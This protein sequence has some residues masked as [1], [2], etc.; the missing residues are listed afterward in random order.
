M[1]LAQIKAYVASMTDDIDMAYFTTTELT[2]YANQMLR[3]TQKLLLQA[4]NNWYVQIDATASTVVNQANYTLPTDFLV[5]NR[6][7]LVQNP[8][9]NETRYSI[10]H[11]ALSQKDSIAFDSDVAGFYILKNTLYFAPVPQTVRTIR[12]YYSYLVAEMTSDSDTPDLPAQY[13]EYL[14]DRIAET[15]FLKDGR[16]ASFIRFRC[17]QVEKAL[18]QTSIER[19]Q[20][21][22][23]VVLCVDDDGGIG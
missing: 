1:T 14:A 20:V 5:M 2:R 8:G 21:G 15:C 13:H 6:L 10:A 16:D 9:V 11:I 18:L 12:Y 23:S 7:E 19:S 3:E 4:G 17:D 22:S